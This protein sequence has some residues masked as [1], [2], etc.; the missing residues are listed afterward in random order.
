MRH[1]MNKRI[2]LRSEDYILRKYRLGFFGLASVIAGTF[3]Y[4]D[5]KKS[6]KKTN[7]KSDL[8]MLKDKA[9]KMNKEFDPGILQNFNFKFLVEINE[10]FYNTPLDKRFWQLQIDLSTLFKLAYTEGVKTNKKEN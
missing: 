9:E 10:K 5:K 3:L 2:L 7:M 8:E 4:I 6:N 1:D